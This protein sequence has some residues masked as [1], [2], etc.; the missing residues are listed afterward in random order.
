MTE[1]ERIPRWWGR[2]GDVTRVEEMDV[3]PGGRWRFISRGADGVDYPF[4]GEFLE[5]DPPSRVVQTFIFDVEGLSD[6]VSVVTIEY[7]E[8]RGRTRMV[9]RNRF[10]SA[11]DLAGA[12]ASGMAKGQAETYDRLEAELATM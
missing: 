9:V 8:E 10:P 6:H 1:A 7:S 12:V 4:K 3:R 5:I 2:L 11:L